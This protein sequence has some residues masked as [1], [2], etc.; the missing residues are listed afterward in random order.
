[1]T[2]SAKKAWTDVGDKFAS[3]GRRVADR[4]KE[5][6]PSEPETAEESQRELKRAAQELVD[7]LSRGFTAVGDTMR[8]DQAKRDLG[9][10]VSAI[11]DAITATVDEATEAIRSGG[12]AGG[13]G[14]TGGS[15]G[16]DEEGSASR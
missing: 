5:A 15:K 14:S 3:W 12:R 11:G 10:A 4:Y 16:D 9:D 1:M 13:R 2:D 6:K 8:D 7:E